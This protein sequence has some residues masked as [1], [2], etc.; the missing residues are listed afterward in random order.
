M[1]VFNLIIGLFFLLGIF[2]C[3]KNAQNYTYTLKGRVVDRSSLEPVPNID[4]IL[5]VP[6][7]YMG[8]GEKEIGRTISDI[9]GFFIFEK[10][11]TQ[12]N[13]QLMLKDI[14]SSTLI[15]PYAPKNGDTIDI[16]AVKINP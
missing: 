12:Y 13:K 2:S 3:E 7:G 11:Q 5:L 1:K 15:L 14:Y 4:M 8:S 16:G 10:L 6:D 9:N